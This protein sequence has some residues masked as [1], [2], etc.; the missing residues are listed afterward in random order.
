[1]NPSEYS[2][3]QKKDIEKRVAQAKMYL[4][5]LNLQPACWMT[6][7]NIGDD[8]FALKATAFLQDTRYT[9]PVQKKD[10]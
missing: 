1:M 2:D 4:A 8:V 6:P 5:G 9:S 3:E 10:I 7:S